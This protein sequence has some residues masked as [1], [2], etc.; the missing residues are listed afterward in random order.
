MAGTCGHGNTPVRTSFSQCILT[1]EARS[2]LEEPLARRFALPGLLRRMGERTRCS[3]CGRACM[4][5]RTV[6][7]DVT[8][9]RASQCEGKVSNATVMVRRPRWARLPARPHLCMRLRERSDRGHEPDPLCGG[10]VS[11]WSVSQPYLGTSRST[12]MSERGPPAPPLGSGGVPRLTA[13]APS[14]SSSSSAF[15]ACQLVR[16]AHV[17]P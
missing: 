10:S 11:H 8:D 9:H 7:R 5:V 16:V 13:L 3:G 1:A 6:L 2:P 14:S 15:L 4:C 17:A 12:S